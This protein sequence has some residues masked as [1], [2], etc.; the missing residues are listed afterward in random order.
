MADKLTID[1][2]PLSDL[3]TRFHPLNPKGHDVG[4]ISE[5][6]SKLSY[7][8][9]VMID[10]ASGLMAAGHGRAKTLA[11]MKRQ[12]MDRPDGILSDGNGEWLVPVVR[13]SEFT[14][15]KLKAY[16]VADN[17]LTIAGEWDN[18]KLATLLVEVVN[19]KE[20]PIESTGF[21]GDK[22][23]DLLREIGQLGEPSEGS[24]GSL[25]AITNVT[26][27]DPITQVEH[28]QVWSI[29]RHKLICADVVTECDLWQMYIAPG[30]WFL[31]YPGV[32]AAMTEKAQT[33]TFIMVQPD[34]Y[35]AGHI[36]DKFIEVNGDEQVTCD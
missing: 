17:Q 11:D 21:D 24:D 27:D 35:I 1:Y 19:A 4:A 5:S 29:G 28:G 14:P 13:G 6:I 3:L 2:M 31:P 8:M 15:E 16:L 36:I 25:L 26:I 20:V 18:E 23:D 34:T 7:R 32:Y 12:Q 22:I 33:E 30:C 9:P 10:E